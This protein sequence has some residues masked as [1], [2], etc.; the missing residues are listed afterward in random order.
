MRKASIAGE[1]TLAAPVEPA[2][3]ERL[4]ALIASGDQPAL[5]ALYDRLADAVYGIARRVVVD[6]SMAEEVTQEVFLEVWTKAA[7]FDPARGSVRTWVLMVTHRRAVDVVRR[8]QAAR[9]RTERVAASATERPFDH[10][11]EDVE[12]RVMARSSALEVRRAMKALTSR[13]RAAVELAY[14]NGHTYAEVATILG[15][16][17]GTAKTRI[18][19]G[20]GRLREQFRAG[21]W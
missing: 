20:L 18:R 14:F 17:L 12:L 21:D 2:S 8:E 4:L 15:V 9:N 16:P 11:A 3:D 6:Q 13:Q 19:D 10:V 7:G 5:G 1:A